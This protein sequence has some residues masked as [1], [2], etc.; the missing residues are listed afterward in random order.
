MAQQ[1][2][3]VR[4][5]TEDDISEVLAIDRALVGNRRVLTYADPVESYIGGTLSASWVAEA[6]DKVKGFALC[7]VVEPG[8]GTVGGAWIELI[9]VDPDAQHQG[10]G[11]ALISQVLDHCRE[12]KL[13]QV[14][15]IANRHDD[16]LRDFFTSLDFKQ[17][18]AISYTLRLEE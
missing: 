18:D 7:R 10:V 9:G 16:V 11:K 3:T 17:G 6:G 8:L 5:M 4:P 2:V 12:K 13:Q 14:S 1:K 15:I